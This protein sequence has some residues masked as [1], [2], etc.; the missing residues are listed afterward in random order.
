MISRTIETNVSDLRKGWDAEASQW[1]IWARA[2]GHDSYWRYHREQFF[3]LLP[4]PGG[5]T[6][7]IGCGEGRLARDLKQLGHRLIAIDGSPAMVAAAREADPAMDVRLADAAALPVAN[8]V[9]D[10]AIAFMSLQ[11]V[12]DMP[13]A[14]AEIARVLKPGGRLCLAIVHP[15][16]SAG[17]F[18][19]PDADARFVIAGDYLDAFHYTDHVERDGLK[20]TF[21]SRHR[22]LETY[23]LALEDAGLLVEALHEPKQPEH[24]FTSPRSPRWQR[25][26]LFLHVRARRP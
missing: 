6:L 26:P 25:I 22:S 7:D 15:M 10:L 1:I 21:K 17:S 8:G 13:K 18:E 5:L 12:D 4:P 16:N 19:Q 23:F 11:D 3:S 14:L 9:A 24:A 2:P 20:M